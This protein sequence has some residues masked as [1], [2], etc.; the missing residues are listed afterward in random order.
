MPQPFNANTTDSK[1]NHVVPSKILTEE[2]WLKH[3]EKLKI[4]TLVSNLRGDPSPDENKMNGT[5]LGIDKGKLMELESVVVQTEVSPVVENHVVP[6]SKSDIAKS[7]KDEND[8]VI[9]DKALDDGGA[10]NVKTLEQNGVINDKTLKQPEKVVKKP[11]P[12]ITPLELTPENQ[13]DEG[14]KNKLKENNNLITEAETSKEKVLKKPVAPENS[15]PIA[16][17]TKQNGAHR[18]LLRRSKGSLLASK[19]PNVL[20][21]SDSNVTRNN[22]IETLKI[23]LDRDM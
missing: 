11:S 10:N 9:K 23:I 18:P 7:D 15:K 1:V 8:S 2:Q 3:L 16:N 21:Y 20:V 4:F 6:N 14:V 5:I 19:P 13:I 12:E 17:A 22:V